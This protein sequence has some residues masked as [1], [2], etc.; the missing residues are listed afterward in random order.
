V[1]TAKFVKPKDI[2]Q[3]W[4][5][6]CCGPGS[7]DLKGHECGFCGKSGQECA[8]NTSTIVAG[9]MQL[10]HEQG[11]GEKSVD[12]PDGP[13]SC[14][15]CGFWCQGCGRFWAG[16]VCGNSDIPFMRAADGAEMVVKGEDVHCVCGRKLAT[17]FKGE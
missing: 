2:K 14:G 15:G 13:E 16:D 5:A 1:S 6:P 17:G 10:V 8:E 9:V 12:N 7:T 11:G 3:W 4:I